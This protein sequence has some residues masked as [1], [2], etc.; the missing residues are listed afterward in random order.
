MGSDA[1]IFACKSCNSGRFRLGIGCYDVINV[2]QGDMTRSETT[3]CATFIKTE[4]HLL[5]N[6]ESHA[7]P[8]L[9]KL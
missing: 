8:L 3:L 1:V 2:I 5:P 4:N 6:F 7:Q 9:K